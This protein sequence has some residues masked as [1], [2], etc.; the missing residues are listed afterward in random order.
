[1]SATPGEEVILDRTGAVVLPDL[2]RARGIWGN[3][4]GLMFR[5]TI[6]AGYGLLFA[7]A[8]GI[9]TQ[10]MRFPIDL[11]FLDKA[12]RV[13]KVHAAIPP[14]RFDVTRA[15][16]VIECLPGTAAERDIRPG[17]QLTIRPR[18]LS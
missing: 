17:D 13:T 11:I 10:F 18:S 8:Q 14:W 2:Q 3:F 15:A 1:M 5:K 4:K 7:P 16:A 6:P 9:H 12:D